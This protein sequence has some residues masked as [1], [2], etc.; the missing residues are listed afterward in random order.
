MP[1]PIPQPYQAWACV[2]L[3]ERMPEVMPGID[4]AQLPIELELRS[5]PH[6]QR[7]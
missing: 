6:E 4:S 5:E 7:L 3:G 2:P 1:E